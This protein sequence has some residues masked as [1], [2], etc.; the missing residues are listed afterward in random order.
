MKPRDTCARHGGLVGNSRRAGNGY[1]PSEFIT[2]NQRCFR[3]HGTIILGS[4]Q[5]YDTPQTSQTRPPT[6]PASPGILLPQARCCISAPP[7]ATLLSTR[8]S[9]VYFQH[10]ISPVKTL[11][12]RRRQPEWRASRLMCLTTPQ[13]TGRHR[14][15]RA[16]ENGRNKG[17]SSGLRS[18][19]RRLG[20]RQP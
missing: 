4:T 13:S 9:L 11:C 14:L 18:R 15:G 2:R 12:D 8:R 6:E 3:V 20:R 16:L 7:S 1:G 17:L 5:R 10:H 19:S